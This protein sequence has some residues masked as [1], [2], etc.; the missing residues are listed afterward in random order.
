ML[1]HNAFSQDNDRL[2]LSACETL[3]FC[4]RDAEQKVMKIVQL[5][6]L[7]KEDLWE[8]KNICNF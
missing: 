1:T 6:C 7:V 8:L 3:A 4:E 2:I 5:D